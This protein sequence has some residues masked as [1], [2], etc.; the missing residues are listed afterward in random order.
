MLATGEKIEDWEVNEMMAEADG[1]GDNRMDFDGIF[2]K[3]NYASHTV[4]NILEWLGLMKDV[5]GMV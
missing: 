4:K 3:Q 2:L 5:E 1:N